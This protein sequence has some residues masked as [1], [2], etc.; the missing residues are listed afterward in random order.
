MRPAHI[1]DQEKVVKI[2]SES[3]YDNPRIGRVVK[4]DRRR[5]ERMDA[6][7]KYAFRF[8]LRRQGVFLTADGLG[9]A[10]MFQSS[11]MRKRLYDRWLQLVL[12]YKSITLPRVF[13]VGK[14]EKKINKFRSKEGEYLY[15]WFLGV[16]NEARGHSQ[17]RQLMRFVFNKSA[18]LRLPLQI[19]TS[20]DRNAKVYERYGFEP[21]HLWQ[22]PKYD[23]SIWYMQRPYDLCA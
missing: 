17:A 18:E 6:M 8:G 11:K 9:V 21:Y 16:A 2:I 5:R 10:I 13:K 4:N 14:L 7:A 20:L 22:G 19:E 23:L 3:F 1:F 15:L 12:A